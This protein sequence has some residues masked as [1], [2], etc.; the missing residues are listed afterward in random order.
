MTSVPEARRGCRRCSTALQ[1]LLGPCQTIL[2]ECRVQSRGRAGAVTSIT[3]KRMFLDLCR[4]VP[5]CYG[6]KVSRSSGGLL[7]TKI[8]SGYSELTV[9]VCERVA[10]LLV[11]SSVRTPPVPSSRSAASLSAR[12]QRAQSRPL[13]R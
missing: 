7:D 11:L 9:G 13:S 12:V 5:A 6:P 4:S 2:G 8:S 3:S 1:T 10:E